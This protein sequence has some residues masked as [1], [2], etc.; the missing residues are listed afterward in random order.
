[1][2][3]IDQSQR[4]DQNLAPRLDR[5]M[6]GRIAV[7]AHHRNA[8][9]VQFLLQPG[10]LQRRLDVDED[11]T[12]VTQAVVEQRRVERLPGRHLHDRA[13]L[14]F[15]R[16]EQRVVTGMEGDDLVPA[17]P[18]SC[19]RQYNKDSIPARAAAT[20]LCI[21]RMVADE[22]RRRFAVPESR[23]HERFCLRCAGH[24]GA[25]GPDGTHRPGGKPPRRYLSG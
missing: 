19:V 12:E 14:G 18:C 25:R 21:S 9:P 13:T 5:A 4:P 22:I 23:L 15:E 10:E 2:V 8:A 11:V 20:V 3:E 17:H 7:P 16:V 1:L 6:P 24:R